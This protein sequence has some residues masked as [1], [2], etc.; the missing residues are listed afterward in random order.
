[1]CAVP[2]VR[3]FVL[4]GHSSLSRP[5]R[6]EGR[7]PCCDGGAF[8]GL[9]SQLLADFSRT[10][11]SLLSTSSRDLGTASRSGKVLLYL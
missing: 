5:W 7:E 8:G 3:E 6:G 1:M 11:P 9:L 10:E 4:Y 2:G